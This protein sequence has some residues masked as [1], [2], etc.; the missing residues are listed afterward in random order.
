MKKKSEY[1]SL[2]DI[3]LARERLRYKALLQEEKFKNSSAR[4]FSSFFFSMK[5]LSFTI[6]NRLISYSFFR[7]L[8]KS[9]I[10]YD[11]IKNFTRGFR[12]AKE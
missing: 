6:R 12:Q 9:N 1:N 2:D 11:F 10:I 8:Y 4:I 5:N 7:S 3:R